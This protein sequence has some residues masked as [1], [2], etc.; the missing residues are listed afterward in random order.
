[1]IDFKCSFIIATP[2]KPLQPPRSA[3]LGGMD[4]LVWCCQRSFVGTTLDVYSGDE[5]MFRCWLMY[6]DLLGARILQ[7]VPG[8]LD[9]IG[10]AVGNQQ[11]LPGLDRSFIRHNAVLRDAQT[12]QPCS[13]RA[14]SA[15][16]HCAFQGGDNPC[17]N[18][19]GCKDRT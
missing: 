16:Q 7:D 12:E 3:R 4:V 6:V 8:V 15:N 17:N 10:G 2:K 14:D 18:R 11:E 9:F 5:S 13:Q 1:M 19:S